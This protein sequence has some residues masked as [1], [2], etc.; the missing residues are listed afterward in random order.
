[1]SAAQL[2]SSSH[3]LLHCIKGGPRRGK[4]HSSDIMWILQ[5]RETVKP[6]APALER[7]VHAPVRPRKR[8]DDPFRAAGKASSGASAS[9]LPCRGNGAR[10]DPGRDRR[11]PEPRSSGG[12]AR[13]R[14]FLQQGPGRPDGPQSENRRGRGRA[15]QAAHAFPGVE[16]APGAAQPPHNP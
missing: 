10:H 6:R 3:V 16:A 8:P 15:A 14:Q 11:D 13:V 5:G 7:P 12:A 2:T 4:I 1:M 9:V